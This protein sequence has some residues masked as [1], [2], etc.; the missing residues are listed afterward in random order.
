MSKN[1]VLNLGAWRYTDGTEGGEALLMPAQHLVTHSVVLGMTGS[2][3]T[4]LI[5][6]LV[7]EALSAG[8]PTIIIDVKGDLPNLLLTYPSFEPDFLRPWVET[9][10]DEGPSSGT[11]QLAAQLSQERQKALSVAS[12]GE[13][14]LQKFSDGIS[15]RVITPGASAGESLHVLSA[16]ER[17]SARW[18]IDPESARNALSAAV[19]L[20]LRLLGRDPDPAKSREHVLLSVLAER[21]L[22][23]G[24]PADIST[25]MQDLTDPPIV[26]IGALAV[27]SF[28]KKRERC[29]LAAALNTLLASP[30]FCSWR[31]GASLDIAEWVVPRNGGPS[32][33]PRSGQGTITPQRRRTPV[34]I[35]SVAHLDE[36]ERTL[37]LGVLLEEI[38]AW[39]RTLPGSERL[40]ALVVFDEVY[41][42]LP[43][44]PANPPTKRPIVALMKQARAFGVGVVVA[45]Q[46]PMDLDYRA[47]SNA[48]LWC[49]GRLQTDADRARVLDGLAGASRNNGKSETDLSHVVQRLAPR[50]FIVKNAHA[51]NVGPVLLNPRNTLSL[52]RGPMTR[53]EILQARQW[54]ATIK[55]IELPRNSAVPPP[56]TVEMPESVRQPRAFVFAEAKP[57]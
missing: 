25:L 50:W 19:S 35:V 16:L 31:K 27:N 41:G 21:R 26:Q 28:L 5:T 57:V 29:N 8:V 7:E 10:A 54:R 34:T 4:G 42:F 49:I 53:N 56:M 39:V 37:V 30:T 32:T 18:D 48:G 46:N 55:G 38:L 15:V 2:G 44:H 13:P 22:A 1:P 40:K 11:T 23:M 14:E 33:T 9:N 52:M 45:T 20:V 24:Q 12:I 47:L 43:P 17:R 6:V 36:E 3:K 51:A